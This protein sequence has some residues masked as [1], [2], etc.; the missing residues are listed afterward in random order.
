MGIPPRDEGDPFIKKKNI[1][2]DSCGEQAEQLNSLKDFHF[3]HFPLLPRN[4][5]YHYTTNGIK[6]TSLYKMSIFQK[7]LRLIS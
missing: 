3:F 2:K 1:A 7:H 5:S 6:N 4:C